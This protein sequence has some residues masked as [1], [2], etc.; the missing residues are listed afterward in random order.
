MQSS[1]ANGTRTSSA[2]AYLDPIRDRPNLTVLINTHVTKISQ[3]KKGVFTTLEAAESLTGLL[4]LEILI[5]VFN[6]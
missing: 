6:L 1:I 2:T 5:L 3:T 4:L